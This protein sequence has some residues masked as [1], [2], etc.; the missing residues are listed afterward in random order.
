M[1]ETEEAY[2]AIEYS[3]DEL[4]AT[5]GWGGLYRAKYLPHEREVLLR[6][7]NREFARCEAGKD[8][9]IGELRAWG[10]LDR[11]DVIQVLDWGSFGDHTYYS[12]MLPEG[13]PLSQVLCDDHGVEDARRIF[14]E[15]LSVCEAARR[16]GVLHLG[17]S[18]NNIWISERKSVQVGEFG[19][20]YAA[21]ECPNQDLGFGEFQAPEL[22]KGGKAS[23]ASDVYALALI[24]IALHLGLNEALA[25]RENS[26]AQAEFGDLK[27]LLDR[28]LDRQPL[29][30]CLSAG[31]LAHEMKAFA[32][33]PPD[34]LLEGCSLCRIQ[35]EMRLG[36]ERGKKGVRQKAACDPQLA[37]RASHVWFIIAAL[38][39]MAAVV[40]WLALR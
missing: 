1:S 21:R 15:L 37:I 39:L 32:G 11:P 8:L 18:T 38:A 23:A 19:I 12:A 22:K 29:M 7:F 35:E 26:R 25:A 6:D 9:L 16:V 2:R 4:I 33:A 27:E 10:R 30:R 17:L 31:E 14:A 3:L 20:W 34:S 13:A 5:D 28:C 36:V 40:W 24:Y